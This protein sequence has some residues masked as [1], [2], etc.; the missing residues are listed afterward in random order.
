MTA[1]KLPKRIW[2]IFPASF[3]GIKQCK[4]RGGGRSLRHKW[5]GTTR[6]ANGCC[7]LSSHKRTPRFSRRKPTRN[8]LKRQGGDSAAP[9]SMRA[10]YIVKTAR[11]SAFPLIIRS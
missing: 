9:D 11:N 5:T 8:E 4:F 6:R 2:T 3:L 7:D 10:C 1:E